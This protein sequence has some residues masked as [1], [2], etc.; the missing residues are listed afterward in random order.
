MVSYISHHDKIDKSGTHRSLYIR[1][2]FQEVV[3]AVVVVVVAAKHSTFVVVV[4]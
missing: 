4:V 2:T 1:W 3:V